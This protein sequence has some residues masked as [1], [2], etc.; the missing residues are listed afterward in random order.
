MTAATAPSPSPAPSAPPHAHT[1]SRQSS[2]DGSTRRHDASTSASPSKVT[3][4]TASSSSSLSSSLSN[5]GYAPSNLGTL[6]KPIDLASPPASPTLTATTVASDPTR[7]SQQT[8]SLL[9]ASTSLQASTT[10]ANADATTAQAA[11]ASTSTSVPRKA[12]QYANALATPNRLLPPTPLGNTGD[13]ATVLS[14]LTATSTFSQP[15]HLPSPYKAPRL[16]QTGASESF[17]TAYPTQETRQKYAS[18]SKPLSSASSAAPSHKRSYHSSGFTD[19]SNKKFRPTAVGVSSPA[20]PSSTLVA[21]SPSPSPYGSTIISGLSSARANPTASLTR[22]TASSP[23][24]SRPLSAAPTIGRAANVSSGITVTNI[25]KPGSALSNQAGVGPLNLLPAVSGTALSASVRDEYLS[26][27]QKSELI[28]LVKQLERQLNDLVAAPTGSSTLYRQAHI[29]PNHIHTQIDRLKA[30]QRIEATRTTSPS[31]LSLKDVYSLLNASASTSGPTTYTRTTGAPQRPQTATR[32]AAALS[33]APR[34][35]VTSTSATAPSTGAARGTAAGGSAAAHKQI[36]TAQNASLTS[37]I[38]SINA[39]VR[40]QAQ[41]ARGP[42]GAPLPPAQDLSATPAAFATPTAAAKARPPSGSTPIISPAALRSIVGDGPMPSNAALAA[43]IAAHFGGSLPANATTAARPAS[44]TSTSA[45]TTAATGSTTARVASNA[46]KTASNRSQPAAADRAPAAPAPT[47]NPGKDI[48]DKIAA[49][50]GSNSTSQST[51]LGPQGLPLAPAAPAPGDSGPLPIGNIAAMLSSLASQAPSSP[52]AG[53]SSAGAK[54]GL[55]DAEGRGDALSSLLQHFEEA[56]RRLP[57][58]TAASPV[59]SAIPAAASTTAVNDP[60]AILTGAS[61]NP[62][63]TPAYPAGASAS[64]APG[65]SGGREDS[66]SPDPEPVIVQGPLGTSTLPSYEDMIVEGLRVMGEAPPRSLFNWMQVTYP[67]TKKFRPSAHQA[68]QKAFKRGRLLK[69]GSMYR[70]NSSWSDPGESRKPT[71]RPQVGR[72]HPM[73]TSGLNGEVLAVSPLKD[74]QAYRNVGDSGIRAMSKG[75]R[76]GPRPYGQ[77]GAAP[78][79]NP[80]SSI[81]QNGSAAS[82][83]LEYQ[84]RTGKKL[85]ADSVKQLYQLLRAGPTDGSAEEMLAHLLTQTGYHDAAATATAAAAA[86]TAA[87]AMSASVPSYSRPIASLPSMPTSA[88]PPNSVMARTGAAAAAAAACGRTMPTTPVAKGPTSL[89]LPTTSE[90]TMMQQ[91]ASMLNDLSSP[92]NPALANS[93]LGQLSSNAAAAAAARATDMSGMSTGPP[94]PAAPARMMPPPPAAPSSASSQLAS[95]LSSLTSQVAQQDLDSAVSE[96]LAA[97]LQQIGATPA[98]TDSGSESARK[99]LSTAEEVA[100]S[101]TLEAAKESAQE[102]TAAGESVNGVEEGIDLAEYEDAIRALTSAFGN[103]GDADDEGVSEE[104]DVEADERA[105]AAAEAEPDSIQEGASPAQFCTQQED[106]IDAAHVIQ[107]S[108]ADKDKR[109]DEADEGEEDEEDDEEVEEEMD[110]S[111]VLRQ[112]TASLQA[113]QQEGGL[114]VQGQDSSS[115]HGEVVPAPAP[116]QSQE[117]GHEASTETGDAGDAESNKQVFDRVEPMDVDQTTEE[118]RDE[119]VQSANADL[120]EQDQ[121]G[122]GAENEAANAVTNEAEGDGG[123]HDAATLQAQLEALVASL[124]ANAGNAVDDDDDDDDDQ[125]D[126]EDDDDIDEED[127]EEGG[128]EA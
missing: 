6:A 84:K 92:I 109:Q 107:A 119:H 123:S 29:Y 117:E 116:D 126:E 82:I 37:L 118:L 122:T 28:D 61:A 24:L 26:L 51:M 98:A 48:S 89:P 12:Q 36:G 78:L 45:Q 40:Q 56:Q 7:L 30:R 58:P 96:T 105:I 88:A 11:S 53:S 19:L 32:P 95:A 27:L 67:L 97:A 62:V 41:P 125:E 76:P 72:D 9:P 44:S 86:Q 59:P 23:S 93:L 43:A 70:I 79:A 64:N 108:N 77:P 91:L 110:L 80:A 22:H 50:L 35:A 121:D 39:M 14:P 33:S 87:A 102:S 127:K 106:N 71:R 18:P 8:P 69:T 10:S 4:A 47:S 66:W 90:P 63:F 5:N 112:L 3:A 104:S 115:A 52:A 103:T 75:M 21:A 46:T 49:I 65:M 81:F 100:A 55:A 114:D 31:D 60:V 120:A 101:K 74:S 38:N 20:T 16:A 99:Q 111:A 25:P 54:T 94:L 68:L 128:H 1:P 2:V 83:I 15:V 42:N 85:E 13:R 17:A 73:V 124:A 57:T 34:R 113:H